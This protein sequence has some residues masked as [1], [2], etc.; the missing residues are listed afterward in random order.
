M[1]KTKSGVLK[2]SG[3]YGTLRSIPPRGSRFFAS[4]AREAK[5]FDVFFQY[6]AVHHDG[7]ACA[8]GALPGG[9]CMDHALLHPDSASADRY[10]RFN[11]FGYKFRAAENVDDIHWNRNV[12]QSR[13][14]L[15]TQ[16]F[17]LIGIHRNDAIAGSVQII[18]NA[19]AWT[20]AGDSRGLRRRWFGWFSE[21]ALWDHRR[22]A[23]REVHRLPKYFPWNASIPF[24]CVSVVGVTGEAHA[25]ARTIRSVSYF[26]IEAIKLPSGISFNSSRINIRTNAKSPKNS[27]NAR[28]MIHES[29]KKE[30]VKLL[31]GFLAAECAQV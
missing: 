26:D 13:V 28:D 21:F 1:K 10:G 19:I 9:D 5:A 31:R 20:M 27:A 24:E 8:A 4:V 16:N 11:N 12:F 29:Y 17:L 3:N 6:A 25:Q 2:S 15:F 23:P 18:G 14:T 7:K 30:I 22:Q